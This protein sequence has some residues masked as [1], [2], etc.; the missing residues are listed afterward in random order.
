MSKFQLYLNGIN[1]AT[2][3][4]LTPPLDPAAAAAALR[5]EPPPDPKRAAYLKATRKPVGQLALPF[6]IDGKDVPRAGWGVVFAENAPAEV[7]A[8]LKPLIDHRKKRVEP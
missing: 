8:A 5:G 1:G 6:N 3:Q 4:Y 7:R 2:G